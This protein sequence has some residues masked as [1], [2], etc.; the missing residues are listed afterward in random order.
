M[1][2]PFKVYDINDLKYL[3][4]CYNSVERTINGQPITSGTYIRIMRSDIVLTESNWTSGIR[5]F[6]GHLSS[7]SNTSHPGIVD[8]CYNVPLF[9]SVAVGGDVD[10][11]NLK[12]A[13]TFNTTSATGLSPFCTE[14]AGTLRNCVVTTIPDKSSKFNLSI[15]SPFAGLCVTN[16]GTIEGCRF[17][18]KA[19]VQSGKTFAGICLHNQSGGIIKGCQIASATVRFATTASKAA[20]ICY[21]NASG[22]KVSDSYFAADITGSA[23]N[24]GGIVYDNSGTV[25]HCYLSSTGH[26]Y[27]SGRVGGIV[28]VN[29]GG[30]VDYCW[31]ATQLSGIA[32]GGVVDS[33]KG[34]Q[35]INCSNQGA[36][37]MI[38]ATSADGVCGGLVGTMTGGSIDN[39]YVYDITL[40]RNIESTPLGGIVAKATAGTIRNCYAYESYH[41]FYG[42]ATGVTFTHCNLVGGSQTGITPRQ[43]AA[44][45]AMQTDLNTDQPTGSKSW[46]GAANATVTPA[47]AGTPPTLAPYTISN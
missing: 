38:T 44:F 41:K 13:V 43:P 28:A 11:I 16:T 47:T 32:V 5:N 40:V 10:G 9:E 2:R 3:R 4:D 12:S 37:A 17:E 39:S 21:E 15:F 7:V 25:E 23:V 18:A 24:W 6:V 20:G 1:T 36:S 46:Q 35:I 22:G 42:A 33:L 45:V 8:S 29:R 14:N 34:G 30:K 27:T 19:E 26:I 31:L